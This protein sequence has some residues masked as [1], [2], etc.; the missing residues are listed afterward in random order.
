MRHSRGTNVCRVS[1]NPAIPPASSM[2]C[3][4]LR[5]GHGLAKINPMEF[6]DARNWRQA[7]VIRNCGR[8]ARLSPAGRKGTE[9]LR[10]ADGSELSWKMEDHLLLSEGFHLRMPDRDR[11]VRA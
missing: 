2:A 10:A 7:P 6:E 11:R 3:R 5:Q 9:R 8:K 4:L 1:H